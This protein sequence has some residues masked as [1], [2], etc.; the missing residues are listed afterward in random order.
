MYEI[1]GLGHT[2]SDRDIKAAYRKHA[3]NLHPDVNKAPDAQQRFMETKMAYE[4]LSDP[5][6]RA[7]Y[8]RRLRMVG[9]WVVLWAW[10]C[11]PACFRPVA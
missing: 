9:G 8:D 11:G 7:E 4:T 5:E 6:A 1:L 2:A 10:F 3:L